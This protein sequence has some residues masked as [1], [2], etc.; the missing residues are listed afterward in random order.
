VLYLNAFIG[1]GIFSDEKFKIFVDLQTKGQIFLLITVKLSSDFF[2]S[3]RHLGFFDKLFFHKIC[4]LLKPNECKKKIEKILD[5]LRVMTKNLILIRH[6][7]SNRQKFAR[8]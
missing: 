2:H 7:G 1:I 4:V 3:S 8:S 6:F 5:S